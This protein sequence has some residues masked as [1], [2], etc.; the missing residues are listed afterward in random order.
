MTT[1]PFRIAQPGFPVDG[2]GGHGPHY[3]R[4]MAGVVSQH[5]AYCTT[6]SWSAPT[7]AR[8]ETFC[9]ENFGEDAIKD[10]GAY[11]GFALFDPSAAW[12]WIDEVF[13]FR[14]EEDLLAFEIGMS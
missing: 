4:Y 12:T 3:F 14:D 10:E 9:V 11:H 2:E 8:G 1:A 5:F 13:Y 6:M 7:I